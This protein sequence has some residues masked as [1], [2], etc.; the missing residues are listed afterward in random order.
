MLGP[1]RAAR[2]IDAPPRQRLH[3]VADN[4][5]VAL[6]GRRIDRWGPPAVR[7][8]LL[9]LASVALW[10]VIAFGLWRLVLALS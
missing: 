1:R 10:T 5:D 2:R 7:F 3:L 8:A 9:L 6:P 4:A